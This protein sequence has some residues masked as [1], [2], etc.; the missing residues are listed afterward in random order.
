MIEIYGK[1]SCPYCDKAKALCELRGIRFNYKSMG[2]D[3]TREDL[4]ETF[5]TARTV[6]QIIVNGNKIGG[7]EQ[8]VKYIEETGYNGTGYTL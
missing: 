7:Y 1:P 3:Y 6:P 8:L 5:P 2:T 4:L